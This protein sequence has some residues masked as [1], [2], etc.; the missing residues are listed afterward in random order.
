MKQSIF[1]AFLLC[2]LYF[3][4][5]SPQETKQLTNS[6]NLLEYKLASAT[7]LQEE[8]CTVPSDNS[9]R[10]LF[11]AKLFI[12]AGAK[13]QEVQKQAIDISDKPANNIY[14]VKPGKTQNIIVVGGHL[15]HVN[16]G[17]GV[18]DDWTGACAVTNI[19]QAIKDISTKHTFVFIGFAGEERGLLGSRAY[20]R[21]LTKDSLSRHKAMVNL[22]CL[23]V[24]ES[25]V[26]VNG[27]D[28]ELVDTAH[29]VAKRENLPLSNHTL[30]GVG[31][32]S[33]S[34]REASIPAITIDGLPVDKF[35][36]I[37]SPQD[38][39]ENVNQKFYYDSYRLAVNYLLE[40]DKID[41][42]LINTNEQPSKP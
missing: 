27:S 14:V 1:I 32:D 13:I 41:N 17:Q 30:N 24:G 39:C 25:L 40:L 28:K 36:F 16:V 7:E 23:G 19:Y 9:E 8:L 38:K 3:S 29:S 10:E 15:D 33:N 37:H 26:W 11:M 21:A 5:A 35:S 6:P 22:E 20:L 18:I 31:A 42:L 2:L 4:I 34:F 12:Q